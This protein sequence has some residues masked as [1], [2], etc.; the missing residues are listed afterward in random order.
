M[1]S[2]CSVML[3]T[4]FVVSGVC[5]QAQDVLKPE[6]CSDKNISFI[7]DSIKQTFTTNGYIVVR[8]AFISMESE[9]E[10][11]VIVPLT[12]GA[13]YHIVFVGDPTSKLNEVRMYDWAENR[14]LFEKKKQGDEQPNIISNSFIPYSSEYYMIK[15]LQVNKKKKRMC[16]YVMLLKRIK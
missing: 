3:F 14:V 10:M 15:P 8:E 13:W 12:K 16:G 11:A 5:V 7:S 4:C 1:K 2:F 9:Y 6:T